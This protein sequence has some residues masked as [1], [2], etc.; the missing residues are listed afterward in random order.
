MCRLVDVNAYVSVHRPTWARLEELTKRAGRRGGLSGAEVDE[1]VELYQ[2]T[3]T[4]LSVI[5]LRS[6]DPVLVGQLSQ[7]VARGRAAVTGTH[8]PAWREV[9]RFFTVKAPAAL[10]RT[11][12][13]S[14]GTAAGCLAVS[15][16]IG[17]WVATH[18]QVQASVAP[19][20]AI[21]ELVEHDFAD[22]YSAHPATAFAAQVWTNNAWLAAGALC[23]G[24]LLG[25]PT[26]WLLWQNALNVGI[27]GGLMAANGKL[28]LFFGLILPHGMLELTAVFV[29]AA[30]GLRLGWTVVDPGPRRRTDA[31]AEEGRAA[32]TVGLA[33]AIVLAV[34]GIIEAFV[35]PSGLPTAARI[36]IGIAAE[37]AFIAYVWVVGGRAVRAGETGDVEAWER[38]ATVAVAS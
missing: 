26:L 21:R 14:V 15:A 33:I 35:T 5:Q 37:L 1:L 10:Y 27:S 22:Y 19:P 29:A 32:M 13:W 31:L 20:E 9:A 17:V 34:T 2:R 36:G 25:L 24:V 8:A 4:H 38:A 11:W 6:P 23:L 30:A 7:L 3:A 12:R 18:P 28:G 16:A